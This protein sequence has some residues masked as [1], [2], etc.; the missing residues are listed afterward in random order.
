MRAEL[1]AIHTALTIFATHDWLDIFTY[2]ISSLQ[3][4]RNNHINLGT[5]SAKYYHYHNLLLGSITELFETIRLAGLRTTLHKRR[6]HPIIRGNDLADATAKL[7][8]THF[9]TFPPPQTRRVEIGEVAP[10]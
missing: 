7:T 4:I 8:V 2:S 5:T 1:V 10:R 9:D 3:A 6:D